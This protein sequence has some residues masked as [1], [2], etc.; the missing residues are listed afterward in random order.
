M[1]PLL[2]GEKAPRGRT[3]VCWSP[4]FVQ[5]IIMATIKSIMFVKL[6]PSLYSKDKKWNLFYPCHNNK[7][8]NNLTKKKA[9]AARFVYA[10]LF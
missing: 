1:P 5:Q 4:N 2:L 9:L 6:P 8:S 3:N 10:N 7:N